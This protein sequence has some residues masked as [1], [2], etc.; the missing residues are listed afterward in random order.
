MGRLKGGRSLPAP[1]LQMEVGLSAWGSWAE[2]RALLRVLPHAD[3]WGDTRT[4]AAQLQWPGLVVTCGW[5]RAGAW[6][7]LP[8]ASPDFPRAIGKSFGVPGF[9]HK[10]MTT[11]GDDGRSYSNLGASLWPLAY[12]EAL[13]IKQGSLCSGFC[14]RSR[15]VLCVASHS[16]AAGFSRTVATPVR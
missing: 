6:L 13:G 11:F 10:G 9:G 1:L 15:A 3:C 4:A 14:P 5:P 8:G 12:P 2:L 7:P 16:R